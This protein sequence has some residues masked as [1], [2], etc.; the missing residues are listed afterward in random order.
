MAT[1]KE[2]RPLVII[3]KKKAAHAAHHG[4]DPDALRG[5]VGGPGRPG[6]RGVVVAIARELVGFMWAIA[7]EVPVTS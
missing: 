4:R 7:R 3:R 5:G 2:Q 6:G 1:P